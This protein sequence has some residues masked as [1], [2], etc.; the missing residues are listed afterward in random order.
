MK[1]LDIIKERR[2][3]R[4]FTDEDVSDEEIETVIDAAR[5]GPIL[6]KYPVLGLRNNKG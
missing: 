4:D 2:S 3:V 6:G 1:V 5:W